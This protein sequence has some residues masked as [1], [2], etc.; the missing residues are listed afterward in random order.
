MSGRRRCGA[1]LTTL[2]R[3]E[4]RP[5]R[6]PTLFLTS[7]RVIPFHRAELPSSATVTPVSGGFRLDYTW[8]Y[9]G[10]PQEG[11]ILFGLN[12]AA[13]GITAK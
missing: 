9:Q 11:S 8:S 5:A 3:R 12:G 13:G 10:K 1:R 6:L 7:R 2:T 4:G